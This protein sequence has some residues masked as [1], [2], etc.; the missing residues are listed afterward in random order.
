[1]WDGNG[2]HDNNERCTIQT[3]AP[4]AISA[5]YYDVEANWDYMR[6]TYPATSSAPPINYNS[7]SGY[8]PAICPGTP[9]APGELSCANCVPGGSCF[10]TL[11]GI[12]AFNAMP[13]IN[14]APAGTRLTWSTDSSQVRGG[15]II[16]FN[17]LVPPPPPPPPP[18]P[19]AATVVVSFVL[20]GAVSDYGVAERTALRNAVATNA[21]VSPA[22]V[23]ITIT[24]ASVNVQSTIATYST[25]AAATV[26][27]AITNPTTGMMA[28]TAALRAVLQAT[29]LPVLSN[30]T[31][32]SA[33]TVTTEIIIGAPS[34]TTDKATQGIIIGVSVGASVI[35]VLA[36]CCVVYMF[37]MMKGKKASTIVKAIPTTTIANPVAQSSATTGVEMKDKI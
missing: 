35:V 4:A 27:A 18:P 2:N 23:T 28:S 21:G 30:A 9:G 5:V 37:R 29:S 31:I 11:S 25:A 10:G 32:V 17:A 3:T 36:V 19:L 13:N 14:A 6:I 20:S 8:A 16:C 24:A 33:P 26:Q 22:D 34:A 1:M 12:S 7:A 15:F